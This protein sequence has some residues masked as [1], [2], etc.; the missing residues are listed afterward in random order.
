[1]WFVLKDTLVTSFYRFMPQFY[2]RAAAVGRRVKRWWQARARLLLA[3]LF[4]DCRP[5]HLLWCL[6]GCMVRFVTS[7]PLQ[8]LL[9][10]QSLK[11]LGPC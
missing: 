4:G 10:T 8:L 9:Q 7:I 11:Q 6:A 2:A 3:G 5:M 1:M